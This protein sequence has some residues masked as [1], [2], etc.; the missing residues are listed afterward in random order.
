MRGCLFTLYLLFC[1]LFVDVYKH[2]TSTHNLY[3][4]GGK[5]ILRSGGRKSIRSLSSHAAAR[6]RKLAIYAQS[7]SHTHDVFITN[8]LPHPPIH[9]T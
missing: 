9:G 1:F 7:K 4:G 6:L 3:E 2:C 5:R 8:E